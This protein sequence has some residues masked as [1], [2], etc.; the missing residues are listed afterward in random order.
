MR[1]DR[2]E[3][4]KPSESNLWIT[5]LSKP[6]RW[7]MLPGQG[8]QFI[9][10]GQ[11]ILEQFPGGL[12]EWCQLDEIIKA[13]GGFSLLDALTQPKQYLPAEW[14]RNTRF[15]HPLVFSFH[16]GWARYILNQGIRFDGYVGYSLG[17]LTALALAGK[18][19]L[20]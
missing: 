18:I 1:S 14:F 12:Q 17:E 5:L 11:E 2:C 15:T 6:S 4:L 16:Y 19:E 9:G 3:A 10:M 20:R 8:S 13:E 7:G